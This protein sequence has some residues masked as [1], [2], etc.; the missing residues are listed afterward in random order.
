VSCRC[1][2]YGI[3]NAS[4]RNSGSDRRQGS[5]IRKKSCHQQKFGRADVRAIA[6]RNTV[7]IDSILRHGP[8]PALEQV[9]L[10]SRKS[11]PLLP[12]AVRRG[13]DDGSMLLAALDAAWW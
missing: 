3:D 6:N 8:S 11:V 7:C 13:F 9:P 5:P 12:L 1:P 10:W 4:G 2:E